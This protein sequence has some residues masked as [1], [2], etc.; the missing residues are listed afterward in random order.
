MWPVVPRRIREHDL[1]EEHK[2]TQ[3]LGVCAKELGNEDKS[4]MGLKIIRRSSLLSTQ[5]FWRALNQGLK[6]LLYYNRGTS[7]WLLV[8]NNHKTSLHYFP[9][10]NGTRF[11]LI[12]LFLRSWKNFSELF[13]PPTKGLEVVPLCLL[14]LINSTFLAF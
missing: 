6:Y 3:C 13:I 8:F 5:S 14:Q 4:T 7:W 11:C 9:F 2:D 10:G 1:G 12:F